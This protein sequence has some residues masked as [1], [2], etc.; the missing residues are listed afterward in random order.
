MR[1]IKTL[2][3]SSWS[4]LYRGNPLLHHPTLGVRNFCRCAS[5][6]KV[7]FKSHI[8]HRHLSYSGADL[9][10]LKLYLIISIQADLRLHTETPLIAR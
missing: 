2:F 8:L 5:R 9:T 4:T 1:I 10:L 3:F 6:S 7:S